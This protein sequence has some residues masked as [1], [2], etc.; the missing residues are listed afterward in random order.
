[1][2]QA[3]QMV[4]RRGRRRRN[5]RTQRPVRITRRMVG[6]GRTTEEEIS[7]WLR[8]PTAW[9]TAALAM[10]IQADKARRQQEKRTKRRRK[11]VREHRKEAKAEAWRARFRKPGSNPLMQ[12]PGMSSGH[13]APANRRPPVVSAGSRRTGGLASRGSPTS[14]TP[15]TA[16]HI[17]TLRTQ[18]LSYRVIGERTGHPATTIRHWIV[19]GRASAI[20]K[21]GGQTN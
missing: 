7:E 16:A 18:G 1:M 19:S 17:L 10:R 13:S 4:K 2:G 6:T 12:L 21:D 11:A 5:P 20:S 15:E 9:D 3:R 14:L 8:P